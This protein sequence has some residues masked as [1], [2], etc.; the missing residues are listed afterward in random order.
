MLDS[1]DC[2]DHHLDHP[3]AD[4]VW[5]VGPS[6]CAHVAVTAAFHKLPTRKKRVWHLRA[7][8]ISPIE[9][10]I[11]RAREVQRDLPSSEK[12]QSHNYPNMTKSNPTPSSPTHPP[13]M[14]PLSLARADP[15]AAKISICQLH[16]SY[17][18]LLLPHYPHRRNP[19][20]PVTPREAAVQ[21]KAKEEEGRGLI[22]SSLSSFEAV[23][24]CPPSTKPSPR[25]IPEPGG[26]KIRARNK[27]GEYRR[28]RGRV[29]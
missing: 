17:P 1:I 29:R 13:T 4:R 12:R 15:S 11:S 27:D 25:P 21:A 9:L 6:F 2:C 26:R 23:P 18:H 10:P 22:S 3:H 7:S 8:R 5:L 28:R 14:H 20:L 19:P 24:P 16:F